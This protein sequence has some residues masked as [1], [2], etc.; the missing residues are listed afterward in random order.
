M[1]MF[2]QM[3]KYAQNP[4][5]EICGNCGFTNGS[6][7]GGSSPWPYNYCPASEDSMNW[8]DGAGTCFKSTGQYRLLP[9]CPGPDETRADF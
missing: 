4:L 2:S 8:E 3:E 1:D 7:H 5:E 9:A 6:H